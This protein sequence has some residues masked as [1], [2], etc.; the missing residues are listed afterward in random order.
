MPDPNILAMQQAMIVARDALYVR[1]GAPLQVIAN[2]H[3]TSRFVADM[4]RLERAQHDG[5][6]NKEQLYE[7]DPGMLE[8][9]RI[10]KSI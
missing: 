1:P 10:D 9:K 3:S 8:M 2:P 6:F 5:K 7:I 4:R